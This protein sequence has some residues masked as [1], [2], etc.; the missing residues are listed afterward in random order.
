MPAP[1]PSSEPRSPRPHVV[2]LGGGH[3]G[4]L[5]AN[6]LAGRAGRRARIT[7]VSDRD[8]LVHR[9]RLHEAA[10]R[11]DDPRLPLRR[12]LHRRVAIVRARVERIDAA[13]RTLH[14]AD[15]T[16]RHDHL[17]YAVGSGVAVTA[18]G[19]REHAAALTSPEA[20]L[21]F[22]ARLATL[23]V[24]APVVVVGGGLSAIET[25]AE[26]AEAHP[27]LRVTLVGDALLPG[28][29]DGGRAAI[30]AGL[31]ELGVEV[32]LGARVAEVSDTAVRLADGARRPAAATVWATG[33]SVSPLARAS[34]LPVDAAGRLLVD[35]ALRVVGHPEIVG[36]GDAVATPAPIRMG[37]VSAMPM[38]AHAADVVVAALRGG[39]AHDRRRRPRRAVPRRHGRQ[40]RDAPA[41]LRGRVAQ[42][43]A[44]ARRPRRPRGRDLRH[45][46]ARPARGRWRRPRRRGPPR[47]QPGQAAGGAARD[48]LTTTAPARRPRRTRRR[49]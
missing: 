30:R 22:A 14:A 40:G 11:G 43:L 23:P 10:A 21:M 8:D 9:V 32:E 1:A 48:R 2:I 38:G 26:L 27:R 6:R 20:A 36:A 18:P 3:A 34:G 19:A 47:P 45:R 46:H 29:S 35:D 28:W 16:L 44:R 12:L 25:A 33:F 13:A 39:A 17:I 31:A 15:R 49:P 7:L 42:R 41:D 24:G 37:C 4:V 5:A